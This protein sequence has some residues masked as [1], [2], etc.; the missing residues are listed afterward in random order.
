LLISQ[1]VGLLVY[2]LKSSFKGDGC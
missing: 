2:W 1:N